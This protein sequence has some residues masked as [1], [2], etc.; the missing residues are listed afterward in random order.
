M[1]LITQEL[2]PA[3]RSP[4]SGVSGEL[5][6]LCPD[7][8]HRIPSPIDDWVLGRDGYQCRAPGCRRIE[9]LGVHQI[10]PGL[11]DGR[12]NPANLVTI[13]SV[14]LSLWDL[15]GRGPFVAGGVEKVLSARSA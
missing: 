14:C 11:P 13:C 5:T 4:R 3:L 7:L 6:G 9:G 12:N 10:T 2:A 8:H 1:V 15:M